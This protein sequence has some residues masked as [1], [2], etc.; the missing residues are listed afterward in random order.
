MINEGTVHEV[1]G[2]VQEFAANIGQAHQ[3]ATSTIKQMGSA[4]QGTSYELPVERW[5][6][7]SSSHMSEPLDGCKVAELV[8]SAAWFVADQAGSAALGVPSG[9]GAGAASGSGFQFY[10]DE[11]RSHAQALHGHADT[12]ASHAQ[13]LAGRPT[14]VSFA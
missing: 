6:R 2:Y 5:A 8:V 1:G 10:P 7:M 13:V 11:L 9:S 14:G 4:Y 3:D 12:V